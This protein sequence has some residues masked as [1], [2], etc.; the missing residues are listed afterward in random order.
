MQPVADDHQVCGVPG[1][2]LIATQHAAGQLLQVGPELRE[3]YK[4]KQWQYPTTVFSIQAYGPYSSI[5]ASGKG[6]F[7]YS[8]R[9]CNAA[10]CTAYS[11]PVTVK[12]TK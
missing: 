9:A 12:V 3:V 8:I 2:L 1:G 5:D 6:T 4:K 7:R 11:A 10:G